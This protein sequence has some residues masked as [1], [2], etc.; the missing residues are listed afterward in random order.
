MSLKHI[1]ND[2]HEHSGVWDNKFACPY[3]W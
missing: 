1:Y 3:I 2:N